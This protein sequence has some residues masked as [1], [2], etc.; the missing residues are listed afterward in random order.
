[1]PSRFSCSCCIFLMLL[2]SL[3]DFAYGYGALGPSNNA[4]IMQLYH[5]KYHV[6]YANNLNATKEKYKEILLALN[7]SGEGPVTLPILGTNLSLNDGREPRGGKL[8]A[9]SVGVQGSA[10][11]WPGFI[12]SIP[13]WGIDVW[14]YA[15]YLQYKVSDVI[16]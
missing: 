9:L 3:P 13:L 5:C 4:Q 12:N 6:N 15:Y 8:T 14:E 10:W 2:H 11:G 1:M 16:I 7:F